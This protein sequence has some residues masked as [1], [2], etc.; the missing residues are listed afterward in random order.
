MGDK[1]ALSIT[2]REG[3]YDSVFLVVPGHE[4][5]TSLTINALEAAKDAAT[6][7]VLVLSV[8]TSGT[9]T[10]F[11]RQFKTIEETT[12]SIGVNH[13]II[14]LPLFMDNNYANVGSI[15]DQATFYDPRDPSKL[16]TPVAVGDVGKAAADILANPNKHS[17]KTYKLV[18]PPYSLNDMAAAFTTS[19]GKEIKPTTVS[20]EACKEAF[21][22][23]GF[24]EW[25]TDGI[26][27]LFKLINEDSDITNERDISDIE[28]I[29]GE[30]ATTIEDWVEQNLPAFK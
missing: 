16:H 6:K 19:L 18:S 14:R 15:K 20:Y 30:K 26:I 7:F 13:A 24:P 5:R 25:Q 1:D 4:D 28:A 3:A 2:L 12:K 23:M 29:T 11:G 9:D 21:M 8:L 22:G 17:G 10:I 27:E